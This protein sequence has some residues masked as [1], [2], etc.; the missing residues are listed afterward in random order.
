MIESLANV[1]GQIPEPV[2]TAKVGASSA[3]NT[4]TSGF[5]SA[6]VSTA[7]VADGASTSPK[8]FSPPESNTNSLRK[9][10]APMMMGGLSHARMSTLGG[11][12]GGG[13]RTAASR[14]V[15]NARATLSAR[16]AVRRASGA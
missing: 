9:L 7:T 8:T 14:A 6:M 2:Y 3:K 5:R 11:E 16:R 13:T 4:M 10:L 12:A 15:S 1:M